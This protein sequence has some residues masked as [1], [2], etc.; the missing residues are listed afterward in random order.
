MV[1]SV[2]TDTTVTIDSL[3][4]GSHRVLLNISDVSTKSIYGEDFIVY[5]I[6]FFICFILLFRKDTLLLISDVVEQIKAP[7]RYSYQQGLHKT[8]NRMY[9]ATYLM[10]PVLAYLI[11]SYELLQG[12]QY[13]H[14]LLIVVALLL[15]EYIINATIE[16][17]SGN[18]HISGF[19]NMIGSIFTVAVTVVLF[20][21]KVLE[22]FFP[23]GSSVVWNI[24]FCTILLIIGLV[25]FI[26][27][28][29]IFFSFRTPHLFSFLYLCTLKLIPLL[30]VLK[31]VLD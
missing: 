23:A 3:W 25:Y 14:A 1:Q 17:I 4:A 13:W 21:S 6:L 31:L 5:T 9:V 29:R 20:A 19:L 2:A 30:I 26:D 8:R 15:L 27:I 28:L 16:Y 7:V 12:L 10:L 18:G 22:M 11:R 24:L